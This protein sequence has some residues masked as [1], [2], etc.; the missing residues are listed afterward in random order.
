MFDDFYDLFEEEDHEVFALIAQINSSSDESG[1]H[2]LSALV[3]GMKFVDTGVLTTGEEELVWPV[4]DDELQGEKGWERFQD[5]Q[6]C[7]LKVRRMKASCC[8]RP[9]ERSWCLSEVVDLDADCPELDALLDKLNTPLVI[10]DDK[11]GE[12]TL[13]RDAISF[14]TVVS[15]LGEMVQVSLGFDDETESTCSHAAAAAKKMLEDCVR[16]DDALRIFAMEARPDDALAKKRA[17]WVPL[18]TLSQIWFK[19]GESFVAYFNDP[20]CRGLCVMVSG[21]ITGGP[22]GVEF[23]G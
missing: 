16:W 3:L 7:R 15:W 2:V 11:L 6:I 23:V 8:K 4:P 10:W 18:M 13:E 12:L 9:E 14:E 22:A 5:D 20:D 19:D 21:T 1:C 17:A